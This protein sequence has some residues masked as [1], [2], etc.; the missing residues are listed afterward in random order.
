MYRDLI[1]CCL[2][3]VPQS[4]SSDHGNETSRTWVVCSISEFISFTTSRSTLKFMTWSCNVPTCKQIK[5][6]RVRLNN[7]RWKKTDLN[8][9]GYAFQMNPYLVPNNR[10][11][12]IQRQTR[13][14]LANRRAWTCI[15]TEEAG[16]VSDRF[17]CGGRNSLLHTTEWKVESK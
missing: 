2:V 8:G 7:V 6:K 4:S 12:S 11:A 5:R 16:C 1:N 14:S 10:L 15:Q 13:A 3:V 9:G 17:V